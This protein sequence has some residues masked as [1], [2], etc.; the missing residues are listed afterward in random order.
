MEMTNRF[1]EDL[2]LQQIKDLT[3]KTNRQLRSIDVQFSGI[4]AKI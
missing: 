1:I 2:F 4:K 3:A